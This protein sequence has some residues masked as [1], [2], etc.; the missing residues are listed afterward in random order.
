MTQQTPH[1]QC[2]TVAYS[3]FSSHDQKKDL[4]WQQEILS[5]YC[6][7]RGWQY[8]IIGDL[9]SGKNYRK[10]GLRQLLALIVSGQVERLVVTH[11]AR[12][13]DQNLKTL[14]SRAYCEGVGLTR[15]NPAYTS[16]IGRTK[17][18]GQYGLSVYHGAGVVIA[19]CYFRFS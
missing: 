13:H 2:K 6:A 10:K 4:E 17:F 12:L 3:R 19:R 18:S 14:V 5:L 11:K 7:S 9:G 16:V 1:L 15:V 8:E